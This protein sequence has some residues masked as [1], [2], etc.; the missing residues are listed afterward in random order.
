MS[1]LNGRSFKVISQREKREEKNCSHLW[2]TATIFY[3]A[4]FNGFSTAFPAAGPGAG[5][6]R[7][8]TG[9]CFMRQLSRLECSLLSCL[10]K[11]LTPIEPLIHRIEGHP[12][13]K[14]VEAGFLYRKPQEACNFHRFVPV[15]PF[16]A[17]QYIM[18]LRDSNQGQLGHYIIGTYSTL[19]PI[20]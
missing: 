20:Y 18:L 19:A 9:H 17:K 3:T 14:L 16:G 6:L 15:L 13:N 2:R 8:W 5:A 12:A 4:Q 10:Q 11:T 1:A 7:R